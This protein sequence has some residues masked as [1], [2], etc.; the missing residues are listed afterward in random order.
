LDSKKGVGFEFEPRERVTKGTKSPN[1]KPV[2]QK[3]KS[4]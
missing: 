4:V 1:R 3:G 2:A